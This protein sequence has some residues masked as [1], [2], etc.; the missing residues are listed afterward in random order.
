MP[1]T[2]ET[3]IH[4]YIPKAVYE[5]IKKEMDSKNIKSISEFIQDIFIKRYGITDSKIKARYMKKGRPVGVKDS[6]KRK[7]R[8]DKN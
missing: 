3:Q 1:G 4:P 6:K 7:K 8:N 5:E 2:K